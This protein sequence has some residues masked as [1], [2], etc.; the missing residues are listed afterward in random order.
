MAYTITNTFGVF[1][2]WAITSPTGNGWYGCAVTGASSGATGVVWSFP[3]APGVLPVSAIIRRTN[4]TAFT[5]S[6]TVNITGGGSFVLAAALTSTVTDGIMT[7]TGEDLTDSTANTNGATGI[8]AAITVT[9]G[10]VFAEDDFIKIEAEYMCVLSIAGN[11]LT[12]RRGELGTTVVSHATALDVYIANKACF[13]ALYDASVA[14]GWGFDALVAGHLELDC[15]IQIGDPAQT[16]ITIFITVEEAVEVLGDVGV[17]GASGYQTWCKSGLGRW[18]DDG[19]ARGGS[20][21]QAQGHT[22]GPVAA[23]LAQ[24]RYGVLELLSGSV[25]PDIMLMTEHYFYRV[26]IGPKTP[27]TSNVGAFI[28]GD[29]Y[30][31]GSVGTGVGE[32]KDVV[33]SGC[34]INY[35]TDR[36]NFDRVV[37]GDAPYGLFFVQAGNINVEVRNCVFNTNEMCFAIFEGGIK[38]F[39]NCV[40]F[41]ISKAQGFFSNATYYEEYTV[42]RKFVA[43]DGSGL[44]GINNKAW[45]NSQD[46]NVDAALFNV[47][48]AA[49][50]TIATQQVLVKT[51]AAVTG[52]PFTVLT[53]ITFIA[54]REGWAR[55]RFD[56]T[57]DEFVFWNTRMQNYRI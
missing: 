44:L 14:G 47:N 17:M 26:S 16:A 13:Q 5:G 38:T 35:A 18:D 6:E 7:I 24:Y 53:P 1:E 55:D 57:L 25:G 45:D 12:C 48:S 36:C 54:R 27:A 50:G 51:K 32:W 8:V 22:N 3:K 10:A 37:M 20:S 42:D 46:P 11:V 29:G 19:S 2:T 40:N 4:A 41:D 15:T 31:F 52:G 34:G 28:F 9:N 56:W 23:G 43:E 39:A 49:D 21:I 33:L 30:G